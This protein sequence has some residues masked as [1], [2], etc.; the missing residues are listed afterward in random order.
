MAT[1]CT[2]DIYGIFTRAKTLLRQGVLKLYLATL[3]FN[4][5]YCTDRNSNSTILLFRSLQF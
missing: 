3:D 1:E 4:K 2:N 5:T